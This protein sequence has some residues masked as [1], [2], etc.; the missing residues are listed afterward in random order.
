MCTILAIFTKFGTNMG[1]SQNLEWHH[2]APACKSRTS[3]LSALSVLAL[4][5]ESLELRVGG[6]SC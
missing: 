4:G 6:S 2:S 3:A 1:E 5:P